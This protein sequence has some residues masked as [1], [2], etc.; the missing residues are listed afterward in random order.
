[1]RVV[2]IIPIKG[3]DPPLYSTWAKKLFACIENLPGNNIH[4]VLI[5]ITVKVITSLACRKKDLKVLQ[6]KHQQLQSSF[7]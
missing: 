6:K 1:M 4:I 3:T 5:A 7:T 2:Q